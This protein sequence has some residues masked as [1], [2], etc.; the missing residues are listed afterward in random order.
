MI[1][2]S[3][4]HA[5]YPFW[6]SVFRIKLISGKSNCNMY[7]DLLFM[8]ICFWLAIWSRM[9]TWGLKT[10]QKPG[11]IEWHLLIHGTLRDSGIC[12]KR[13]IRCPSQIQLTMTFK[14]GPAVFIEIALSMLHYAQ[15]RLIC[16]IVWSILLFRP[17]AFLW[18]FVRA[19]LH[20]RKGLW[21][22]QMASFVS[23]TVK[24]S[25]E[26]PKE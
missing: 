2:A 21:S 26:F 23:V 12:I 13:D 6:V 1:G 4:C 14:L 11:P 16:D 19:E 9:T 3:Q 20:S 8:Q 7:T 22:G 25:R 15:H 17:E 24:S 10:K 18:R 5:E